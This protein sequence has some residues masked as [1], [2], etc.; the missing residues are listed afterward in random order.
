MVNVQPGAF[1]KGSSVRFSALTQSSQRPEAFS[2]ILSEH[3]NDW[4]EDRVHQR[5]REKVSIHVFGGR[6]A[7]TEESQPTT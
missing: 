2:H 3:W 6:P 1:T 5:E 4:L 7:S